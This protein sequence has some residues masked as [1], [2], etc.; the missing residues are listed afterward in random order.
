MEQRTSIRFFAP[1]E[2]LA[3]LI[4]TLYLLEV[5][6][7]GD[8][9]IVD[10]LHPEWANLRF[11]V[12]GPLVAGIG[13]E[14]PRTAPRVVA[15]GPTSRACYFAA[16]SMRAWGIG[17][18]PLGW[19]RFVAAPAAAFADR[20][21]D[22]EADPAFAALA[23]LADLLLD[24]TARDA[25]SEALVINGYL[26]ERLGTAGT[27]EDRILAV[28]AALVDESVDNV[29]ELA[30][31]VAMTIR[32]LERFCA[33]HFGF[34]PKL[35]LRRQRFLRS[36]A[37]FMIDPSLSWISTLDDQ[38]YDQAHFHR[39]FRRFMGMRPGEYAAMPHPVMMA[40]AAGRMASAGA[41]MQALHRPEA[42]K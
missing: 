42:R 32:S 4:S 10:Y 25:E 2:A 37:Q 3:P 8:D 18:L 5:K 14:P 23:P 17:L 29:T 20:F 38:Y 6:G 9:P 19:A 13:E 34:P 36:L 33:R 30:E 16:S 24:G 26:V 39:D 27:G 21:V 31:R 1:A 35:L 28:H 7:E 22:G 12:G 11:V 15:T 41:A 40:A